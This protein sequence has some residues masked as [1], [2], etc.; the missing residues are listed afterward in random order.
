M[1][2]YLGSPA[3][4]ERERQTGAAQRYDEFFSPLN[5]GAWVG[6]KPAIDTD[7]A[8]GGPSVLRAA[9]ESRSSDGPGF[10]I[11]RL[12]GSRLDASPSYELSAASFRRFE[13]YWSV[14]GCANCHGCLYC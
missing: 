12:F 2:W 14:P 8:G 4:I 5:E 1:R 10:G 9:G 11:R 7:E 6:D 3:D 13:D